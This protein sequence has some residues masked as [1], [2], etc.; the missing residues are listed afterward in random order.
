MLSRGRVAAVAAFVWAGVIV[1]GPLLVA[2]DA[3]WPFELVDVERVALLRAAGRGVGWASV[4]ASVSVAIGALLARSVGPLP[5]L[6]LLLIGRAILAHAVLAMGLRPGA[7]AAGVAL[8]GDLAPFAALI[9]W[10]RLHTR[11]RALIEA[12]ADLGAPWWLRLREI[13]WPHMRPALAAAWLWG[14]LQTL[15]DVIAFELAGGGHSYTPGL[16]IRDAWVRE[17]APDR[18]LVAVLVLVVLSL[19]CAWAITRELTGAARADWRPM[20]TPRWLTMLGVLVLACLLATPLWLLLGEHPSGFSAAD[21]SLADATLRS[22][23]LGA[24]VAGIAC[25]AGFALALASRSRGQQVGAALLLPL[26]IPPS[27]LGLLLL[28][29]GTRVGL[30][31]GLSL[32]LLALL[33]PALALAFVAARLLTAVIPTSLIE[34]AADLGA[35]AATRLRLVWL[36]LGRGALLIGFVIAFAWVLGQ[37]EIP[38]FTTGPGQHTLAVDLTIHARAGAMALVRRWSTLVLLAAV[39]ASTLAAVLVRRSDRPT[40]KTRPHAT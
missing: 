19:I 35:D 21:R 39:L 18:A 31:P 16:L 32:T 28:E 5:C 15:G 10:L 7:L 14:C 37:A 38:G 22:V 23:G 8:V 1:V 30:E 20:P 29:T 40:P 12:A 36:P 3:A 25:V 4:L 9:V 13:E 33:G 27:V 6:A 26:A 2:I 24:A 11:P 17:E 34:C